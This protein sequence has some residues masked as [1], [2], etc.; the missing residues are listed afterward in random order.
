[1]PRRQANLFKY[2]EE[3]TKLHVA[4]VN[5]GMLFVSTFVNRGNE[6]GI[7]RVEVYVLSKVQF[8]P[9]ETERNQIVEQRL[10]GNLFEIF[11]VQLLWQ[12]FVSFACQSTIVLPPLLS[13]IPLQKLSG[14]VVL[15]AGLNKMPLMFGR[16][17]DE[18]GKQSENLAWSAKLGF[19]LLHYKFPAAD[20]NAKLNI[21]IIPPLD[22]P[23]HLSNE[24]SRR[25]CGRFSLAGQF[26]KAI[27]DDQQVWLRGFR[28]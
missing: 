5:I 4:D 25:L 21:S 9:G 7:Y 16:L 14:I 15:L 11:S 6:V 12:P 10:G 3:I 1:M 8:F 18:V 20:Q 28:V 26:V 23:V 17:R 27:E 2:T 24:S 19:V 22:R 13:E